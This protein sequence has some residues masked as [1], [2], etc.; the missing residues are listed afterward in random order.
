[1][2]L[3]SFHSYLKHLHPVPHGGSAQLVARGFEPNEL[4]D[5]SASLVPI[6]TPPSVRNAIHNI[7]IRSYPDP[8]CTRLR[9]V[10]AKKHN[11][12][13]EHILC[14]NGSVELI[15]AIVRS[16]MKEND[17]AV[18]IGPTFGEYEGAVRTI[19]AIP[20]IL[21]TTDVEIIVQTIAEHQP[22]L[23]FLCNPNNPT[24]HLWK[25]TEIDRI[26]E[27][28][29]LVLD[30]A[31]MGFVQPSQPPYWG[32]GRFILRSLTKD[33]AMAGLRIGYAIAEPDVIH[34]VSHVMNPWGVSTTAQ[35]AAIAALK[36]PKPYQ[37]AIQRL[38]VERSRLIDALQTMGHQ[39]LD[40]HAPFFLVEVEDARTTTEKMLRK[41]I[42]VRDCTSFGLPNHIRI[43][44]QTKEAGDRLLAAFSDDPFPPK[45]EHLG[46]V[47]LVFGGARS[48][49]SEYAERLVQA[50]GGPHVTY[51]ATAQAFDDEM[52]Q[53]I[54]IH[55][56]RR[57]DEWQTIEEPL[58]A[59]KALTKA[60]HQTVL[61]DCI[62]LLAT[63]WLLQ[64]DAAAAMLEIERLLAAAK[65]RRGDVVMV[66]NEIGF[67]VV[68]MNK[69]ARSF[70]DDQGRINQR[71]AEVADSVTLVVAGLPLQLKK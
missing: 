36:D 42:V 4:D 46:R 54:D 30:E 52:H 47:H 26:A 5:F 43:S 63:N 25:T 56:K 22:K 53:R 27:A 28:A 33:H 2:P 65:S 3:F 64:Y 67:G 37:Q 31:Y 18:I 34:T 13:P 23:V 14:G 8:S 24:G 35:E 39:I 10:L 16:C 68:P 51:M 48:G 40:G 49:K 66:S 20:I 71:I 9:A 62:T 12:T 50:L 58:H 41:K 29:P 6:Q 60:D 57:D 38:W 59:A 17:K 61:V 44:P 11:L 19:G 45:K 21:C 69:L 70:R 32:K 1:M 15:G 7:N 55:Q